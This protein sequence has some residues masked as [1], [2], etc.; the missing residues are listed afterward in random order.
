MIANLPT[1]AELASRIS[2]H[3]E[4]VSREM[5]WLD[6]QGHAVKQGR[7]LLIPSLSRIRGLLDDGWE[8]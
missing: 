1:H 8:G 3:R 7:N 6:G 2:T 5:A 4:A